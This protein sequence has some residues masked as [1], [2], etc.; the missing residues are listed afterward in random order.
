[1]INKKELAAVFK[2][3]ELILAQSVLEKANISFEYET[4]IFTQEFLTPN[5]WNFFYK[6]L[7][8]VLKIEC[9]GVFEE[10]ERRII[11]FTNLYRVP[12]PIS[13][14]KVTNNSKFKTL[15]HKDYLGAVLSIGIKRN[16]IGDLIIKNNEC[17][18]AVC[19]ELEIFICENLKSI[20]KN[21]CSV[22]KVENLN[23]VPK[24][25]FDEA[26][27]NVASLRLDAVVAEISNCS[28]A[29]AVKLIDSGKVL[30]DYSDEVNKS[31]EVKPGS[32]LTVR[33]KGKYIISEVIG[34]TKSDK[35]KITIKKYT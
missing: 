35:L 5:M 25:A 29:N 32:R 10:S 20:G 30:L 13:V 22:E 31:T 16:R 9:Y 18:L 17:Y 24:A 33:G 8:S 23:S 26:V 34:K 21:P 14:L 15:E 27:I 7:S 1:M 3:E 4:A 11:S 2:G 6:N 12:Y 28:R 19:E